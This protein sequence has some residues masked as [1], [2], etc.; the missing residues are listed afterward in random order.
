M[1]FATP[2]NDS[3][4]KE[5]ILHV[6]NKSKG[7]D[8]FGAVKLNKLLFYSDFLSYVKRGG[9]ITGQEYFALPEGPAPRRMLPIMEAMQKN[10]EIAIQIID[11]G[12]QYQM[13]KVLALRPADYEVL[14]TQDVVISDLIIETF[15]DFNGTQLSGFTHDFLG[16]K[17]AIKLGS[18][19]KIPYSTARFD[20]E[21]LFGK[22][23]P[24]EFPAIPKSVID[25]GKKLHR[26]LELERN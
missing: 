1:K 19:T 22:I 12:P 3:K 21:N 4:M 9:S 8:K 14:E 18:R 20:L 24:F 15:S 5:L 17:A 13:K 25:F 16:W 23:L 2:P 11:I 6:A 26:T 7:D 10:N